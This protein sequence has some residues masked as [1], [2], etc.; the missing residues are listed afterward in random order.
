MSSPVLVFMADLCR[1]ESRR[2]LRRAVMDDQF[3]RV[4]RI[5]DAC[6]SRFAAVLMG[7]TGASTVIPLTGSVELIDLQTLLTELG[8]L[9]RPVQITPLELDPETLQQ[10]DNSYSEQLLATADVSGHC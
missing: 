2:A 8:V 5:C 1:E 4:L 10:I 6:D 3:V 7:P 9:C